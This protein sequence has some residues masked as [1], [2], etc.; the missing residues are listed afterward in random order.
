M[1]FKNVYLKYEEQTVYSD[2][3]RA[4][5]FMDY[6]AVPGDRVKHK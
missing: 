4:M 2:T 5:S 1:N 6:T 3:V